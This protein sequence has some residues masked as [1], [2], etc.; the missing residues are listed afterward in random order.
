META[1]AEAEPER[2]LLYIDILGFSDMTKNDPRKV[3]RAYSILNKLNAHKDESFKTIVFSDTVLV[4]NAREA[5]SDEDRNFLVWYLTEF[6]EDL[7]H[8][9]VGQDIWFRAVLLAGD[10]HH[11]RLDNIECFY[12]MALIQAYL[13]E[14]QLP[15]MG[16]A[17]HS[18]CL[19]YNRFFR[20][21]PFAE[22]FSFVYLS[23]PLEYLHEASGDQYPYPSSI[24]SD[25]SPNVPEGIRY[26]SDIHRLMRS[27]TD[28]A[29]RAKALATW[30]FHALRYPG[31][32]AA[33]TAN[34]F[35]LSALA[36]R[37]TWAEEAKT[38]EDSIKYYKRAGA[39]TEMSISFTNR[40]TTKAKR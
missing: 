16:L 26:L 39:G 18:S 6:A 9:L 40:R 10:F 17:L 36:P 13:A 32:V 25:H 21:A 22:D 1:T 38:L 33:L 30:D 5:R 20:L 7:Y 2:F 14:K 15:M 11:Y 8:R 4:Y 19:P 27:H 3:A 29:V 12:G 23:R 24:V 34:D 31:M 28:P 37:G 35:D